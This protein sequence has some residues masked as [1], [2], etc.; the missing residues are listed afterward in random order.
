MDVDRA[1]TKR[2]IQAETVAETASERERGEADNERAFITEASIV[3]R[4]V[5][6]MPPL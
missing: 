4:E 6:K 5:R 3:T 2:E 1:E